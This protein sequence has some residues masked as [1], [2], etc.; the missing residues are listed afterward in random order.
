MQRITLQE[1]FRVF[2]KQKRTALGLSQTEFS[3]IIFGNSNRSRICNI[4]NGRDVSAKTID[5]VLS[6]INCDINFIEH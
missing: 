5:L 1:K 4:E 2:V 6:K 3:E